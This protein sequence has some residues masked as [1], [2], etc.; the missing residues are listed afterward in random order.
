MPCPHGQGDHEELSEDEGRESDGD[1]VD[2]VG[3]KEDEGTVHDDAPCT[4]GQRSIRSHK[5]FQR[6]IQFILISP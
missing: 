6:P 2:E 4:Q 1:D 3:L 5:S